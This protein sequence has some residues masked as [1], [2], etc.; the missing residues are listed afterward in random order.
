MAAKVQLIILGFLVL[1]QVTQAVRKVANV[2]GISTSAAKNVEA[3]SDAEVRPIWWQSLYPEIVYANLTSK[4]KVKE[5]FNMLIG[6]KYKFKLDGYSGGSSETDVVTTDEVNLKIEPHTLTASGRMTI[7]AGDKEFYLVKPH[8]FG[9]NMFGYW[10]WRVV[11]KDSDDQVLFTIQKSHKGSVWGRKASWRIFVGKKKE[12]HEIYYGV[13]DADKTESPKFK[14]YHS[15]EAYKHNK[16]S[17]AAKIELKEHERDGEDEYMVKVRPNEDSVLLLIA[18]ICIDQVA[19][20]TRSGS[21]TD[22]ED[23]D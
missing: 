11:N 18:S 16:G 21:E 3:T 23:S 19:D 2:D 17:Y 20:V 7:T 14:F 22:G 1:S 10:S 15:K 5:D 12:N 8:S 4:F 9:V 6:K 13:G